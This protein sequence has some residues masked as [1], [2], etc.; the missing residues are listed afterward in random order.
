MQLRHYPRLFG[1]YVLVAPLARG[2]MGELHLAIDG[3][4]ERNKL[5]VIK[6][7]LSALTDREF[8]ARFLRE[9]KH[10]T[11]LSHGNLV[12]VFES[13]VHAGR[14]FLVMEYIEGKDLRDVWNTLHEA[15]HD[16]PLEVVLC[17]IKQL[18][19]G[20]DYAHSFGDLNLIHRD[21]S[22]PNILLSSSGEL[23]VVDFGLTPSKTKLQK[24]SPGVFFSK[25][26]YMAPE[27]AR[28]EKSDARTDIY[29]VGIILWELI[30]GKRFLPSVGSQTDQLQRAATPQYQPPSSLRKGLPPELDVITA[31]ALAPLPKDR[32]PTAEAMR[33]AVAALLSKI[34]AT[35]DTSTLRQFLLELYGEKLKQE[36]EEHQALLDHISPT[37]SEL[38]EQARQATTEPTKE[39]EAPPEDRDQPELAVG[40][41]LG[42]RY[43]IEARMRRG[44]MGTVYQA[45]HT[46]IEK[47]VAVKVLHPVYRR[48]PEVASRFRQEARA[49]S[50]IGHP[51]I[52]EIFDSG[53]TAAGDM[54]F[55]M[56][57]L[58][59]QDLA[60]LLESL[61]QLPVERTVNIGLQIC[62]ALDA[63]HEAG[64]VHRD[65]KPENI[66]LVPREGQLDFVKVLDFGVA[67][68]LDLE[69]G[70][71]E[72]RAKR[73]TSPGT[74][75]G[76]PEYMSPEQASGLDC[77]HRTDIYAVGVLLYEMLAGEPPHHGESLAEVLTKKATDA[78]IPLAS[79]RASVP[80]E[81][82][83]VILRALAKSPEDRPQAMTHLA[84]EL[85]KL[86][87]G[88]VGAVASMLGLSDQASSPPASSSPAPGQTAPSHESERNN[89]ATMRR[90]NDNHPPVL[91]FLGAAALVALLGIIVA[92]LQLFKTPPSL[93]ATTTHSATPLRGPS[94][95][96]RR[97]STHPLA[98]PPAHD[99]GTTSGADATANTTP[100]NPAQA[101]THRVH[102]RRRRPRSDYLRVGHRHLKAGHFQR[103]KVAFEAAQRT[104]RQRAAALVGLA[105]VAFQ[106]RNYRG[107]SKQATRALRL[108]GGWRANLWLANAQFKLG[109]HQKAIRNYERVLKRSPRN[110]E[111]KRNL[112]AARQALN[113]RR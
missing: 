100:L 26:A 83:G 69:E 89:T 112:R 108:G 45:T 63:A 17:I 25:L 36:Q 68:T 43:R 72:G 71:I 11:R 101:P 55:V 76:T 4:G 61:Q 56:E 30:T 31:R 98:A 97:T 44:G 104:P 49:A 35:A 27:Q 78:I 99:S 81:L 19:C 75:I 38:R 64:I 22:P 111:A 5:F 80:P 85:N 52:I 10:L 47:Q 14:Y 32:F 50:R 57:Y 94:E 87:S 107:A 42:E 91:F 102:A 20:L 60:D 109:E 46:G 54:Y 33:E 28:D 113:G 16:F 65:L 41:M 2:G 9:A 88:R 48:H 21:M 7:L 96:L 23:R 39:M 70:E 53:T 66:F 84:Y 18:C 59:G 77:D 1:K 62:H 74:A 40:T 103:A 67:Q 86:V 34:D 82:D 29:S 12:P 24:S 15:G 73:L 13:G 105:R 79:L 92:A 37:I 6:E 110:H 3:D 58:A 106:R 90:L 95:A 93:T 8:G 51:N